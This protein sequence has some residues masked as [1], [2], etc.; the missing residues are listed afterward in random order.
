MG[1][2]IVKEHKGE[3]ANALSQIIELV[4]GTK[5]TVLITSCSVP[6]CVDVAVYLEPELVNELARI[7]VG[8]GG[9]IVIEINKT[10][11]RRLEQAKEVV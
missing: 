5:T 2:L 1:W 9:V 7:H 8:T 4:S 11:A 6:N 3:V 10:V